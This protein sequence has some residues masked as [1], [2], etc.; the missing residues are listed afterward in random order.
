MKKKKQLRAEI[1]KIIRNTSFQN[2]DK[3]KTIELIVLRAIELIQSY[4]RRAWVVSSQLMQNP[5]VRKAR[6]RPNQTSN[7]TLLSGAIFR[8]WQVGYGEKPIVNKRLPG[9]IPSPFVAFATKIYHLLHSQNTIDNLDMYRSLG[10][11]LERE[12][13]TQQMVQ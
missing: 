6:G 9:A 3:V 13:F 8:A 4:Q 7:R 5:S 11:C 1:R 12:H 2:Q 10:N